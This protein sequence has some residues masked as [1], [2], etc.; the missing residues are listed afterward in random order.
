M[1]VPVTVEIRRETTPERV[2]EAEAW[3]D[4]GLTLVR[5]FEGY[6]GG[7]MLRDAENGN[8]LHAVYRFRDEDA[9]QRW[10]S[11]PERQRWLSHGEPIVLQARTQRRTGIEGWFDGPGLR[12]EVDTRTGSIRTIG[13]RSAPVRWKQACA[14]WL[15]MFPMNLLLSWLLTMQ[16]WWGETPLPLRSAITVTVLAPLMTFAVMPAVTWMLRKWLRRNPG[17]IRSERALRDAL[18]AASSPAER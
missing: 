1:A 7:G 4:E 9:L 15:G 12:H 2:G 13:V 3:V 6:L 17:T 16:P 11:S 14:I 8:V 10:E 5:D 18:D